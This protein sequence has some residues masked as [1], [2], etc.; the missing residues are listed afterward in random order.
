MAV[1][2][3]VLR[4][5]GS[6]LYLVVG[7]YVYFHY[8]NTTFINYLV[9]GLLAFFVGEGPILGLEKSTARIEDEGYYGNNTNR[10]AAVIVAI[11]IHY[12]A[13][14]AGGILFLLAVVELIR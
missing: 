9:S 4:L 13:V 5:T 1:V 11:I 12:V 14:I 6:I 2:Q 7:L 3:L 10:Q 8:P